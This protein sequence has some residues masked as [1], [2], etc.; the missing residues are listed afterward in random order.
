M[1]TMAMETAESP[2][3]VEGGESEVR[4]TVNGTIELVMP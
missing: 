3:A 4:V 2:V 1:A